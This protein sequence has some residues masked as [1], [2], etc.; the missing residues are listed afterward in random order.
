M[1][2]CKTLLSW[3]SGKDS[4]WTLYTLQQDPSIKLCGLVTTINR[5]FQR[6]AM[7]GVRRELLE[8]Q[9]RAAGLP[10]T[11]IELPYPCSNEDYEARMGTL[12]EQA[13]AD[14][15]QCMAFGDLFLDDI[16]RYREAKLANTGLQPLFPLWGQDTRQLARQMLD[17]GLKAYL[18]CVDP[19][20]LAPH[21]AG[22][23]FSAELLDQLPASVD[24]CGEYGEFHTFAV[25]GPMFGESIAVHAGE[26]VERDGFVFADLLPKQ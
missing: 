19:T 16:R 6:V 20:K 7:H 23:T 3:S 11:I 9:A 26:I 12:V 21:W 18:T 10:L 25:A 22:Q 24:P 4:A 8:H 17:S 5:V 1:S 13:V 15:V 14:G 2:T